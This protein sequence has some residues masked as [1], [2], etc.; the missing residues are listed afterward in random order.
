M[1]EEDKRIIDA[2]IEEE[3]MTEPKFQYSKF[4]GK[5]REAQFV[6]RA[7][8][9]DEFKIAMGAIKTFIE[10]K[11]AENKPSQP[12]YDGL[13]STCK[14]AVHAGIPTKQGFSKKTGKPYWYHDNES[15]E[16]CFGDGYLPKLSR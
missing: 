3:N 13:K 15:G 11:E 2:L 6:V 8:T 9:F 4:V 16:R 14:L 12:V 5:D 10:A 7:D 1:N